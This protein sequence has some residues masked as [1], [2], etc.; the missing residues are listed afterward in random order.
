MSALS[1]KVTPDHAAARFH[2]VAAQL[3]ANRVQDERV[4]TAMETL[5]REAFVPPHLSGI[6]YIDEDIE[7]AAGRYLLEPMILAR[8]LQE[9]KIKATD[10]VLDVAPA[11][12]YSTAILAML[13]RDVTAVEPDAALAAAIGKNLS[14]LSVVNARVEQAPATAG[15]AAHAPYDV[16]LINGSVDAVPN[17]LFASLAEGGRLLAVVTPQGGTEPVGEAR[18]YE[19]RHGAIA[20]RALFNANVKPLADFAAKP[21]FVF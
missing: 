3:R 20:H 11:T 19:K 1:P 12:G 15:C 10:A 21:R 4:L 13:A 8:L 14:G 9:A 5:P 7:V 2:M 6:A 17:I 16:I 18:L